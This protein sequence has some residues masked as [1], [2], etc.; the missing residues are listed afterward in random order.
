[1]AVLTDYRRRIN[2]ICIS[3]MLLSLKSGSQ[4]TTAFHKDTIDTIISLGTIPAKT[5]KETIK[6]HSLNAK[7]LLIQLHII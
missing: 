6:I 5:S 4:V 3:C 2:G 7:I 1:M